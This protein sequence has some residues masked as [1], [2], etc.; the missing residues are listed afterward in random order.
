MAKYVGYVGTYTKQDSKG[1]YQFTLDTDNKELRDVKLA[2]ELENPTYVT[3][4][5]DDQ[6]LYAVTKQG[7]NGG[8]TAFSIDEET[9]ELTK[10]NSQTAAGSPPCHV[11]VDHGK[12][13][14]VTA[15]Y[16]TKNIASYLTKEDGSLNPA[17]SVVEHEGTGPHERQE[18]PHL[19]F[20]GFT[21][22]ENYVIAI[23]LGSDRVITYAAD[24]GKLTQ[25]HVFNTPA[26]AGPRHITFHPNQKFAYVMTELS[27][28][29]LVLHY[30]EK[31][32]SFTEQQTI[33][34]IPDDFNETNDGSAIHI[35]SDGQYVYAGNRGHNSIAVYKVD[36]DSGQLT[37]ME[38]TSTE[39]NWPRDF[40]LDPSEEFLIA[41]NQKSNTMTLFERDKATGKLSLIQ[42]G[43]HV[44]EPVCVKFIGGA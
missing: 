9:G 14:V 5:D 36:Q 23:D 22:D 3:V 27:S 11:S 7:E 25:V 1:V 4:S 40:V 37:F 38:W 30:D 35:S 15:N 28:D 42:S 16:H 41:T 31:D 26:G 6:N 2:A 34:T 20:A 12:S 29:V 10:L 17:T 24:H 32:G 13:T 44:P 21:P 33:S 19:H 39:G 8:V 43:V 18:K